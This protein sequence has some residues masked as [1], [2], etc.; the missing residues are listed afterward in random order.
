MAQSDFK[1]EKKV[2]GKTRVLFFALYKG[3]RI[4]KINY[5][6]KYD[7]ENYIRQVTSRLGFDR[8]DAFAEQQSQ[9]N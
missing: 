2:N 7:C 3:T 8:L 1:I 9:A 5:A 6:R 4:N